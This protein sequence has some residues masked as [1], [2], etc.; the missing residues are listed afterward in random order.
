M[1][2]SCSIPWQS[3]CP[4]WRVSNSSRRQLY[5]Y[6][7]LYRTYPGIVRALSP[8]FQSFLP[9]DVS[10]E[11]RKS[12]DGVPTIVSF[13]GSSRER[14]WP[15]PTLRNSFSTTYRNFF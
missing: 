4:G 15:S 8:Q 10:L 5:R 14:S 1:A 12:G 6:L 11:Q 9:E 2:R 7:R 13:S 3:S